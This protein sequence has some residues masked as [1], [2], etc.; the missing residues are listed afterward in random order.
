[1]RC[2]RL[3]FLFCFSVSVLAADD[4]F[5]LVRVTDGVYLA[6]SKPVYKHNSNAAVIVLDDGVLVADTHSKPSAARALRKQIQTVTDKPVRYVVDTHFHWDHAWGNQA[7]QDDKTVQIISSEATYQGLAQTGAARMRHDTAVLPDEIKTVKARL[8]EATDPVRKRNIEAVIANAENFLAEMKDAPL[9]LPTLT[10]K[11]RLVLRGPSRTAELICLGH[12]HSNGDTVI[13]LPKEKVL[14]AGDMVHSLMPYMGDSSPYAWIRA[15]DELL[16]L[17][18]EYV[19]GG[20]GD[21]MKG[22][23]T[24][25]LWRDYLSDLMA[26]TA[27][28]YARG[29]S[30][31]EAGEFVLERLEPKYGDKFPKQVFRNRVPVNVEK[32]YLVVSL[33]AG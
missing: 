7:Y 24:I 13:Y 27:E 21:A 6:K 31:K 5:E 8:A 12:A 26:E 11:E 20:H 2:C 17:D 30:V 1:M 19:F 28:A 9:T 10:F 33:S 4:L 29:L 22:K 16:K 14:V 32:A 18:I 15:L 3:L 25:Q 23:A